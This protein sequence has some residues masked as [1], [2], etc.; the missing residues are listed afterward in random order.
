MSM[1]AHHR[2]TPLD[3]GAGRGVGHGSAGSFE[4]PSSGRSSGRSG[5]AVDGDG[6]GTG[7]DDADALRKNTLSD[8]VIRKL[9]VRNQQ[10]EV[11]L[12]DQIKQTEE[13]RRGVESWKK[14]IKDRHNAKIEQVY[15]ILT[16]EHVCVCV[17]DGVLCRCRCRCLHA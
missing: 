6:G 1:P 8:A 3:L 4:G 12:K 15:R 16:G 2:V 14:N 10:L 9:K 17:C 7:T 11:D 5:S 13:L